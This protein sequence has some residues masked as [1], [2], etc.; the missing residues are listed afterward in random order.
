MKNKT[1]KGVLNLEESFCY[2]DK[3]IKSLK[4]EKKSK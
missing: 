2:P 3:T 1:E 4:R